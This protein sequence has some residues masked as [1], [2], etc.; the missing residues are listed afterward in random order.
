[1]QYRFHD[2]GKFLKCRI[3]IAAAMFAASALPAQQT[4][5]AAQP[6]AQNAAQ[7]TGAAAARPAGAP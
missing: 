1:M 2:G 4:Q 3:A 6:R 5:P 7:K